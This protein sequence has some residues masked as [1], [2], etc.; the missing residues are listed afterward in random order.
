VS[1]PKFASVEIRHH[2]TNPVQEKF[3]VRAAVDTGTAQMDRV[4]CDVDV[5]DMES[6]GGAGSLLPESYFSRVHQPI[7]AARSPRS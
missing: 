2:A 4:A 5:A 6:I 1:D 3:L 7:G